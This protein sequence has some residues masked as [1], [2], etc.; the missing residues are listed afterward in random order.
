MFLAL[1]CITL[2]LYAFTLILF[3]SF[4]HHRASLAIYWSDLGRDEMS[5]GRADQAATSLR[6]ALSY[7]PDDRR[8][9][10]L[11]AEA[12]AESGKTDQAMNYFLNLWDTQ[13]GD[14]FV[15]LELARLS[16]PKGLSQKAVNYYH[17]SIFGDWRG[18]GTTRRRSVRLEL[19]RLSRIHP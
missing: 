2:V 11:L 10:M 3:Q 15:N 18:D 16:R 14:G 1:T 4:E 13:P 9:E 6:N 12:L 7:A 8:Y 19:C 5:H 17:A